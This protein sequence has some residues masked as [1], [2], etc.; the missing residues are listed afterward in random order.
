MRVLN[1]SFGPRKAVGAGRD[2]RD[3]D[4]FVGSAFAGARAYG[5]IPSPWLPYIARWS[6]S[7]R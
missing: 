2:A 5:D 4:E 6:I 3:L 7:G 1:K